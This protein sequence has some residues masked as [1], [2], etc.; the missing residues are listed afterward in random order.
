MER[1]AL[2][3]EEVAF[4]LGI[5]RSKVYELMACDELPSFKIG[6][7]RRVSVMALKRYIGDLDGDTSGIVTGL[8]EMLHRHNTARQ[9]SV[10]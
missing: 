2:T 7:M 10:H 3:P 9:R 1:L 5:S 6:A 4:T 8:E